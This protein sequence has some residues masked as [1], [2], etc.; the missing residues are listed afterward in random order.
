MLS[1]NE[2]DRESLRFLWVVDPLTELP[3]IVTYCFTRVVFGVLSS[4]FL[5]NATVNHHM[6]MNSSVDPHFM[7][8]FCSSIYVDDHVA[9]SS[10]LESTFKFYQKLRQRLAMAGFRLRKFITNSEELCNSFNRGNLRMK[11]GE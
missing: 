4:P 3:E 6:E 10:D 8:K 5:L 1:M 2:R 11:K 7:D 9:G